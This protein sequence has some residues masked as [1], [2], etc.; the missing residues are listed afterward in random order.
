MGIKLLNSGAVNSVANSLIRAGVQS[1]LNNFNGAAGVEPRAFRPDFG[2]PPGLDYGAGTHHPQQAPNRQIP[3]GQQPHSN[4]NSAYNSQQLQRPVLDRGE[5]LS[6]YKAELENYKKGLN[7][8]LVKSPKGSQSGAEIAQEIKATEQALKLV[9]FDLRREQQPQRIE[10][11]QRPTLDRNEPLGHYYQELQS[12]NRALVKQSKQDPH[13]RALADEI[14]ETQYAIK[15]VAADLEPRRAQPQQPAY[16]GNQFL[17]RAADS[18]QRQL[19]NQA[20]QA[21]RGLVGG[22]F[23]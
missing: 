20:N 14:K 18:L 17:D 15:A 9:N 6:H 10:R 5:P 8:L 22:L 23:R 1:G 19:G 4:R 12:Y 2:V 21:V 11:L 3:V 16:P 13:N 7:G